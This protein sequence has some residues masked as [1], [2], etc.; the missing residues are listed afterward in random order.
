MQLSSGAGMLGLCIVVRLNYTG[1]R[2]FLLLTVVNILQVILL[3]FWGG[4][5]VGRTYLCT[6]SALHLSDITLKVLTATVFVTL[7]CAQYF[8]CNF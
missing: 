2:I 8:I 3:L 4:G 7:T 6:N 5:K 1:V